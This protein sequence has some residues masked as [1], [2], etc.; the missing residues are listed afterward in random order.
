MKTIRLASSADRG[1]I[2]RLRLAEYRRAPE[3][4]LVN[5]AAVLW[6][7]AGAGRVVLSAWEG[8]SCVATMQTEAADDEA[9]AAAILGVSLPPLGDAYPALVLTRAATDQE[10]RRSGLNSALRYHI[11]LGGVRSAKCDW[12]RLRR[13][14]AEQRA[15]PDRL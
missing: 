13:G 5:E 11:S 6:V 10:Y 9:Q 14:A 7:G 1:A 4:T 3:F 15:E 2:N 12:G 8:P